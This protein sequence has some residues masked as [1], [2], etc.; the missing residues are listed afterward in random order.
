MDDGFASPEDNKDHAVDATN[1][2]HFKDVVNSG[3]IEWTF[4]PLGD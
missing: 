2:K 3:G 4:T 1:W